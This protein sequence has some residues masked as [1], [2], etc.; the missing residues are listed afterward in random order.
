MSLHLIKAWD[1]PDAWY[2][3][4]KAIHTHGINFN[5]KRGSECTLTKKLA[6]A[7]EI[8]HPEARPLVHECAPCSETYATTYFIEYLALAGRKEEA[9]TYGERLRK[10]VDQI[11]TVV[12]KYRE[13][14]EDRQNTMI[15]RLP[16][17]LLTQDPPCLTIIDTEIIDDRLIF[18]V[19]F[20]SW[21]CYAALPVN[22][23]GLQL[24]NEEMANEI[25]V[26]SG[27]MFAYSKN[28]HLYERQFEL[29]KSLLEPKR[30]PRV[31]EV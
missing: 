15:I 24:L 6:V 8:Q 9:Y 18:H 16:Q 21:D 13:V 14:K 10:P 19:Y 26:N 1:L 27:K 20:R 31:A 23:A 4:V 29:A 17:D 30:K 11:E 2:Q 7:V 22:L 28:L 5:V 3:L 12:K 25:G